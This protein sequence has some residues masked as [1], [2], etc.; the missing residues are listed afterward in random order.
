MSKKRTQI[1]LRVFE[2]MIEGTVDWKGYFCLAFYSLFDPFLC[3]INYMPGPIGFF[4]RRIYYKCKLRHMGKNVLIDSGV[5]MTGHE[6]ISIG[7]YTWIDQGVR[8]DAVLGPIAIGKRVHIAPGSILVSG[9]GIIIEDYVGISSGVKIYSQSEVPRDGK[10]MSGP[11]VPWQ[12]KAY[13]QKPIV[14]KKDGFIGANAVI[15]P[16]VTVH[17][18][19]VVG[20][21]TLI[22]QDLPAYKIAVCR[23]PV[24]IQDRERV[25]MPEL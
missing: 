9:G 8:L 16:G 14:I 21:N 12:H 18:G 3:I 7:D 15:L 24:V 6:N 11:M 10:R 13:E 17:E 25:V 20:A 5:V 22:S 23:P 4:L 19:A 1:E 2:K